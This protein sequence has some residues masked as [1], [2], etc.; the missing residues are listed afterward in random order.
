[1]S[2]TPTTVVRFT[3]TERALHWGF[4]FLYLALVA[5]G[6]PLMFPELRG[7]IRGYTSVIGFRLHLVCGV[8]WV[9]VTLA[10][11]LLGDRRALHRTWRQ[12]VTFGSAD[13]AWLRR[14]PR[15]LFAR[16]AERARLDGAVG[17]FNGG[18]KV[19]ALFTIVTSVLLLVSGA[20]L[21]PVNGATLAGAL[22]GTPSV[23]WWRHAHGWLTVLALVPITGHVF[24]ALLFPPT[25]GSLPG[26]LSGHVDGDWAAAH[27]PRWRAESRD[28]DRAA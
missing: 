8:T 26:M 24:L 1:M 7:W 20:A 16:A 19:N 12:L 13:A 18:Q 21:I 3:G 23:G 28:E 2:V 17:R 6:L 4:A 25:R 22:T 5:S 9:L 10:V 14:F 11:I 27:H 15:W